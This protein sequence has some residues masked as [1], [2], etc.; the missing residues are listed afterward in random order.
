MSQGLHS[1]GLQ[2]FEVARICRLQYKHNA[3]LASPE[4]PQRGVVAKEQGCDSARPAGRVALTAAYDLCMD[5][6][7]STPCSSSFMAVTAP[8]SCSASA[9]W[10]ASEY[11]PAK[12]A[13]NAASWD[14]K[15]WNEALHAAV[16]AM[17][18]LASKSVH[19]AELAGGG[20]LSVMG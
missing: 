19:V 2:R 10:A 6:S 14:M 1:K 18:F 20:D 4:V 9:F 17:G 11:A 5:S 7:S 3:H 15:N 8:W 13:K 16:L 12:A